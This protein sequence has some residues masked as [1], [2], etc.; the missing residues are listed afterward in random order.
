VTAF[1]KDKIEAVGIQ[2]VQDLP[3]ITPGLTSTNQ[4]G[5]KPR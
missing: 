5:F 3:N 4:A 1:S 2:T